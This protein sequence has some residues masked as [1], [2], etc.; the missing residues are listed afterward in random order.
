MARTPKNTNEML[1]AKANA[2]A[3]KGSDGTLRSVIEKMKPQIEMA[4]VGTTLNAE[5]FMRLIFST[6][7]TN[8][9]L[10]A[11]SQ[12]SFLGAMMS[13]AQ[14]GLEP[15]TA[16]GQAYLI[17]Y[18]NQCQFQ[19]GY[20]GLIELAY[21]S[22]DIKKIDAQVVYEND[23]FEYEL[24]WDS[25]LIH[26]PAM[27]NRGNPI[28][29]YALFK[30]ADGGGNFLFMSQEDVLN[31]AKRFSKTFRNGPWQTD[32]E[33]MAKKTVLKM[34][35]KY[36]P[37]KVELNRAIQSDESI[38]NVDADNLE[39]VNVLDVPAEFIVEDEITETEDN[40]S[41]SQNETPDDVS[42]LQQELTQKSIFE[43]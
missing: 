22:G 21:R 37:L 31:H 9:K 20:K 16:L 10:A 29:Y 30:M 6:I 34:L 33:S 35:L 2:P 7:S 19:L 26:K 40:N 41:T 18:G 27:E 8:P 24:G 1:N 5:R 43:D 17:P 32:F 4:V 25:K 36:A 38:K 3:K 23:E 28:G 42:K 15:N 12:S 13:A 11:C 39:N 14:L